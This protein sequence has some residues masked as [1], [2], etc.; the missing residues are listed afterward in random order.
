MV[1]SVHSVLLGYPF[2]ADKGQKETVVTL[3]LPDPKE[4]LGQKAIV[5]KSGPSV[6]KGPL[7]DHKA[8]KDHRDHQ[9]HRETRGRLEMTDP[10]DRRVNRDSSVQSVHGDCKDPWEKT[11]CVDH[12]VN[13]DLSVGSRSP[14]SNDVS[15]IQE[16]STLTETSLSPAMSV[17][18][19]RC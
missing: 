2:G 5:E 12:R 6:L 11:D 8:I 18:K 14:F 1:Q 3:V 19:D 7:V 15:R 13:K 4:I 9:D 16:R 10:V 17:S